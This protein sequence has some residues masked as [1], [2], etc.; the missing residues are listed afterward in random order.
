MD[1]FHADAVFAGDGAADVDAELEDF[2]G[3]AQRVL[4]LVLIPFIVKK[5]RMHVSVAGV[6]DVGDEQT[7][8]AADFADALQDLDQL[9]AGNAGILRA[10]AV[11][12]ASDG[13]EGV[14]ADFP[15]IFAAKRI[16]AAFDGDG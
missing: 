5:D 6:E 8:L 12:Y 2:L 13:A 16:A 15:E 3:R 4:D 14:F 9:A 1:F 7:V 11:A 10:I